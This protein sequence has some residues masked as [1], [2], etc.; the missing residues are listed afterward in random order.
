MGVARALE[1]F[2][3]N[4]EAILGND[5]SAAGQAEGTE[6]GPDGETDAESDKESGE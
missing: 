6:A 3:A 4:S 5:E 2:A 1:F